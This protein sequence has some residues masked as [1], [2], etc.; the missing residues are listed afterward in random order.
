MKRV[1]VA[2][3]RWNFELEG[4]G[5][6]ISPIGGNILGDL[7]PVRGTLFDHF[8]A[9]DCDRRLGLMAD[10]GLNCLRQAIGC[11]RVFDPQT[12][13]RAEGLR[14]WDVFIKLAEK[15][16]IYLMPVG[17]YI[18]GGDWFDIA[19]L[20]DGDR[21]LAESCAFWDAFSTHY[22]GHPAIWAWDLRNELLYS[23]NPHFLQE[24]G[25]DPAGTTHAILSGWPD[26]LE[27]RYGTVTAMSTWHG[28]SYRSFTEVPAK[29][30]F[31]EAPF[32]PRCADVR[33]YLNERGFQWCKAQC[34]V[35]RDRSPQHMIVQGNNGWL[36]PDQDLFL[37]NG[38]HNH[39]LHELFDFVT[40]HPYPAHQAATGGRGDPLEGG[41]AADYWYSA[42]I[43]MARM[44]HFGKPIVVQEFGW[45]GGGR[46][47]FLGPLPVRTEEEHAEYMEFLINALLPHA[48]GFL[49]WPTFDMPSA[50]DISN[51][52]GIF[53]HD[54]K[55]K[56]L[57]RVF[58]RLAG[59][60]A[61]SHHTRARATSTLRASLPGLYTSR[62]EQDILW[63]RIHE[64]VRSGGV[65]DVRFV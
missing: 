65:P 57:S 47:A 7:H 56:A 32:D 27:A 18:G 55:P 53:T 63:D 39:A 37:A 19:R 40:I 6:P 30:D 33:S 31:E 61:R 38:F 54:G 64:V 34:D 25:A 49:N 46:S 12:G 52:G 59:R 60:V 5:D 42:C 58:R 9:A 21:A 1:R 26:W 36:S 48:N 29:V 51:H 43:G 24:S 11:N 17:G 4:S 44:E 2:P 14:H 13:L 45:Y 8:D 41:A 28:T 15:H 3:D 62:T 50:A 20:A 22:A 16:G 23:A 10:L 35:I